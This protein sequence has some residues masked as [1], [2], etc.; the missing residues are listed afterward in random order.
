MLCAQ[1][2]AVARFAGFRQNPGS[3]LFNG[4]R[5]RA[6]DLQICQS[7]LCSL[8]VVDLC[9][10]VSIV[11]YKHLHK[12]HNYFVDFSRRFKIKYE[13]FFY[14]PNCENHSFFVNEYCV[15]MYHSFTRNIHTYK[16]RV[17][18]AYL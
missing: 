4:S 8:F 7:F 3:H 13:S 14:S 17:Y 6:T 10:F 16:T 15:K 9:R 2:R 12:S 11:V 5:P 18:I 1:N